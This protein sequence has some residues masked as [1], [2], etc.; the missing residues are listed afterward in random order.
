VEVPEAVA[1]VAIQA[2]IDSVVASPART[3]SDASGG[4]AVVAPVGCIVVAAVVDRVVLSIEAVVAVDLILKRGYENELVGRRNIALAEVAAV[5]VEF[6][7]EAAVKT[8]V[9]TR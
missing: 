3:R 8:V 9:R 4:P 6:L 7:V 5:V 1:E 2:A